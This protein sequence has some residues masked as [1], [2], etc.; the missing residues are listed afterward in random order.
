MECQSL[1][2]GEKNSKCRLLNFISSILSNNIKWSR[3][4]CIRISR[5][6]NAFARIDRDS[7][8][9]ETNSKVGCETEKELQETGFP[10][11]EPAGRLSRKDIFEYHK[12][13]PSRNLF[14][15]IE[16]LC[17]YTRIENQ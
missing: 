16:K 1:L 11:T 7:T 6:T 9:A 5:I 10:S 17:K 14:E 13:I 4:Y 12:E 15:A 8:H 3:Q 2:S